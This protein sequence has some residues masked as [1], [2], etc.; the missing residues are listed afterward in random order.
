MGVF[1]NSDLYRA[2]QTNSLNIPK[3]VPF[4]KTGDPIWDEDEYPS[5]PYVIVGDDAFQLS[6]FMM[7]P[8]SKRFLDDESR[9]YNYRVS[10][11][12]RCSENC[13]GIFASRFRLFLSR[14]N[15]KLE[16]AITVVFAATV[17]HNML[18]EKS[19]PSYMPNGYVDQGGGGGGP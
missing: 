8:Y 17:L 7:K 19:R 5:I 11:F 6:E 9:I 14:I 15:L 4:P 16:H 13:F 10:R 1:K 18:C 2:L 12:R 3:L